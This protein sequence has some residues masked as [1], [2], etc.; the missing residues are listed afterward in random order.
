MRLKLKI[1]PKIQAKIRKVD[2]ERKIKGIK[3]ESRMLIDLK[4]LPL[5]RAFVIMKHLVNKQDAGEAEEDNESQD[6]IF[7]TNYSE[8][9]RLSLVDLGIMPFP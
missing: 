6:N 7:S 1:N 9:V 5:V 3:I 2:E 4:G 8:S